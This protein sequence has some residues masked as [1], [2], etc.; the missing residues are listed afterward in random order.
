MSERWNVSVVD[1]LKGCPTGATYHAL[2]LFHTDQ[3]IRGALTA[4]LITRELRDYAPPCPT[5][6][7]W[8]YVTRNRK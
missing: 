8:F 5:P 2:R 4:G 1:R 7:E 6:I 3:E